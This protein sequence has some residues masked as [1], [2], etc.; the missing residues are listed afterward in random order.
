MTLSL[1]AVFIPILFMAGIL[2]RLFREFAVTICAAILISGM[3]SITPDAH[4]V[5]PLPA[6]TS[7][8]PSTDVCTARR[9]GVFE[10]MLHVYDRSL[11][12]VLRHRPVMLAVFVAVLGA[13]GYLYV[14]VPKGFIPDADNDKFNVKTEAAQGT[15]YLPDGGVPEA[16]GRDRGAGPGC[17]EL[18]CP[19]RAA[20]ASA[21]AANTG[22]HD[23]SI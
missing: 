8:R 18:L 11:R 12:W 19:A 1:A 17:R 14:M 7:Q 16:G 20:A 21:A 5:Q 15:S 13:T 23:A 9:S 10:G 6:D 22:P 3:V 4:A 2:G